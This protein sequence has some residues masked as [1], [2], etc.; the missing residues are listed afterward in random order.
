MTPF[1]ERVYALCKQIP[2]GKVSTYGAIARALNSSPRAVGQ[3]LKKNQFAPEVPCH[4]VVSSTGKIG[5]FMGETKGKN[6]ERKIALL[7]CEGILMTEGK[8]VDFNTIRSCH[9]SL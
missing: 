8:I 7:K 5:G 2:K 6:I 4:R 9:F 1:E 3:A